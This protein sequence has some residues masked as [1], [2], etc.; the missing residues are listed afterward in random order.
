MIKLLQFLEISIL[1]KMIN[2]LKSMM[3]F[4]MNDRSLRVLEFE[5]VKE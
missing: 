4:F 5:K 2:I 1:L 3:R